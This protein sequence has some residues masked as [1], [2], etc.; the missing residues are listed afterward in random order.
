M[1]NRHCLLLLVLVFLLTALVP[2]Q[3]AWAAK[4]VA[5]VIGNGSYSTSPLKNPPND[6][7]DVAAALSKLGFDVIEL[8][9][10]HKGAFLNA[11]DEFSDKL[12]RAEAG[13]FYF[14]GHGMQIRGQNYLLP[15][16]VHVRRE[17]DRAAR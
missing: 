5:L 17:S 1:A 2:P 11:L 8:R 3:Q 16:G 7:R 6:A 9:D 13:L 14:A 15:V 10:A 12:R 4:R